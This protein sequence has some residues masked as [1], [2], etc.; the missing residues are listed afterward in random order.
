MMATEMQA[1]VIPAVVPAEGFVLPFVDPV[2]AAVTLLLV[3]VFSEASEAE[4]ADVGSTVSTVSL[5]KDAAMD[6]VVD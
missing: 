1:M 5:D 6:S 4:R 2:G 3:E